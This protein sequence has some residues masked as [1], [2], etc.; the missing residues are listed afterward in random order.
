MRLP[1]G[2]WKSLKNLHNGNFVIN[3]KFRVSDLG[4]SKGQLDGKRACGSKSRAVLV[5]SVAFRA[6]SVV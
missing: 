5:M 6:N 1:L 4:V 3:L 2:L